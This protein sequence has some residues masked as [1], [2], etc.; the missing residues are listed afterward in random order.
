MKAEGLYHRAPYPVRVLAASARGLVLQRRRYGPGTDRL[1][2]EVL[3]RENW[4]SGEWEGWREERLAQVLRIAC[5]HVS[6]YR[7]LHVPAGSALD[8]LNSFPLLPKQQL[9]ADPASF[10][11]DDPPRQ[12]VTEHTSGTTATPLTLT[13][14]RE[15]YREWYALFEARWRR[16]YGVSRHD[17]WAIVGGQP[18]VPPGATAPPFWVWNAAMRQLYLSS[19]HVAPHTA[20]SYVQAI[21]QH[22]VEYML[23]YPSSMHALAEACRAA[24][25]RP[26]PL[27]VVIANAEPVLDHQREV[28]EEVF[29]CPVRETY[30]MA[31]FVAAASECEHGRLHLWPEVGALEVLQPD[32]DEPVPDGAMGRLVCTGLLNRTMPL[33]RYIV[34]DAGAVAPADE[35]CPCGRT[36]PILRSVEGRIDDLVRT[37]DG[38]L[39]GR[40]DPVFKGSLPIRGAQIIQERLDVFRVLI[41]PASGYGPAVA[42]CIVERLRDRVGDVRVE[43]DLIEEFST[44]PNGKFK[45]VVSHVGA[46]E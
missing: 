24:G 13:I 6:A 45:A 32:G 31:E 38:R 44:G 18:V 17:R 29:G 34:G 27:R 20:A 1:V 14:S 21:G 16:W 33:I 37:P 35:S 36:L 10:V 41:V 43:I 30:G 25:L 2:E 39:I 26:E 15:E 40:L 46:D 8:G 3:G 42:D 23:G 28:I 5:D 11:R 22:R 12:L 7:G 9:R 19:Y 4:S